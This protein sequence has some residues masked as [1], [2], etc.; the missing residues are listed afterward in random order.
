MPH[1]KWSEDKK[2]YN[3]KTG[4]ELKKTLNGGCVGYWIAG[5]WHNVNKLKQMVERIP[6]NKCPF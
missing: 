6:I 5:K 4:R 2:L 3:C 1:Y